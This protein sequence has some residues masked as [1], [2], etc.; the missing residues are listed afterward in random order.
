MVYLYKSNIHKS[1]KWVYIMV[2]YTLSL[3]LFGRVSHRNFDYKR[4]KMPNTLFA[5]CVRVC[6]F[7]LHFLSTSVITIISQFNFKLDDCVQWCEIKNEA[8]ERTK[9]KKF[10]V[11]WWQWIATLHASTAAHTIGMP[12]RLKHENARTFH[13]PRSTESATNTHLILYV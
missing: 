11:Y 12:V 10:I 3:S 8:N 13:V 6:I 9:K 4:K 1:S 2:D 7:F 5:R